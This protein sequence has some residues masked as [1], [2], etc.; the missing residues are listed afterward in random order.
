MAQQEKFEFNYTFQGTKFANKICTFY[1]ISIPFSA[2]KNTSMQAVFEG[3]YYRVFI[4]FQD[5]VLRN[6]CTWE[7]HVL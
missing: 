7:E 2:S 4:S 5:Q 1:S 3:S 6:Y